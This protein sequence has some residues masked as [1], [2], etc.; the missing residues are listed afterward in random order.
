V[1]AMRRLV[2]ALLVLGYSLLVGCADSRP[3]G[4]YSAYTRSER[5]ILPRDYV[6]Y[7]KREKFTHGEL[8]HLPPGAIILHHDDVEGYLKALGYSKWEKLQ[9]GET[10]PNVMYV[11]RENGKEFI[12]NRGLPGAGGI[13]TQAAEL[14]A[15]GVKRIIHIGTAG[16]VGTDFP[17]RAIVVS[18]GS[19]KDG[20]AMMLS[21]DPKA[22]VAIPNAALT[23]RIRAS[24]NGT[25]ISTGIG[26]TSPIFYYQPSNLIRD[27]IDGSRFAKRKF[28]MFVEMEEAP[29]F[30]A[31]HRARIQAA[32]IVIGSDRYTLDR[33]GELKHD[34]FGSTR[35]Q[36]VTA[37]RVAIE[38]LTAFD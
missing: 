24:A 20:A 16:F 38:A 18:F 8:D 35:E 10:D 1:A 21:D 31:A 7:L 33:D 26:F 28:P 11:V 5:V 25:T 27:L 15:L 9:T 3:L 22:R 37:L 32:S 17:D 12:V 34:Y 19:Y 36:E 30:E 29:L 14:A 13:T 4:E 6:D 23:D 2:F